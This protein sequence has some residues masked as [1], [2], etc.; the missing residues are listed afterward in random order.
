MGDDHDEKTVPATPHRRQRMRE[1]GHVAL[2]AELT[3]IGVLLAGLLALVTLGSGLL[4][5][6]TALFASY[7]S[8]QAWLTALAPGSGRSEVLLGQWSPL[9]TALG[10]ALAPLLCLVVAAAAGLGVLQTG[11][12]FMPGRVVPD[13][14]RIN[15]LAGLGR[16]AS[17]A[18]AVRFGIGLLRIALVGSV[19][20]YCLYA[21]RTKLM[22][23]SALGVE[24]LASLA[25]D[26]C[27]EISLKVG[28]ALVVLAV[29]D[30]AIQ[31]WRYERALKMTPQELREEM[32]N[33]Q[34]HPGIV[35]RR[36][37]VQSQVATQSLAATVARASVVVVDD[38]LAV[39]LSYDAQTMAAPQVAARGRG[40]VAAR[41]RELATQSGV[42]I[43]HEPSLAAALF[44]EA[45]T[46][47][48]VPA[49]RYAA[50][51]EVLARTYHSQGNV[52][53]I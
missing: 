5:F 39:A 8:G 49:A 43:V 52:A 44:K 7:L 53:P 4:Q 37:T 34:G 21:S 38:A 35:A 19:G 16:M 47:A 24:Q 9:V 51:A 50:V 22:A 11:F 30:Y 29:A 13:W 23:A 32:R 41:I 42:P 46:R 28:A 14:S 40:A 25:R 31:R 3:S 2:S 27:L 18:G 26:L 33:L 10:T 6:L 1:E 15:P 45:A 12:F 36:R 20:A 48:P 17:T